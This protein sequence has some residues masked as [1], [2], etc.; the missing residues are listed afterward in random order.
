MVTRPAGTADESSPRYRLAHSAGRQGEPSDRLEHS[1]ATGHRK[2]LL[3]P[4]A[5]P[6]AIGTFGARVIITRASSVR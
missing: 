4:R 5:L 1:E 3:E 2:G 6:G